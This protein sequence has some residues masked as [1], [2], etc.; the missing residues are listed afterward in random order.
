VAPPRFIC[1]KCRSTQVRPILVTAKM[2]ELLCDDCDHEWQ[3]LR[4]PVPQQP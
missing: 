4:P 2:L 3:V 1:P